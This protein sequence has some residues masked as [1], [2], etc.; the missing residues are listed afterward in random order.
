MKTVVRRPLRIA[1]VLGRFPDPTQ[2]FVVD[3]IAGI[4][5]RGHCVD[6][7]TTARPAR[8]ASLAGTLTRLNRLGL[9]ERRQALWEAGR[10]VLAVWKTLML[11]LAVGW[12]EPRVVHGAL[13]AMRTEGAAGGVRLL[14]AGLT[15]ARRGKPQYDAIHAQF[16]PYGRLAIRLVELDALQGPVVTSFRGY[17]AGRDLRANPRSY[18]NLFERGALF[19]PVSESL[20][21]RLRTGG[22]EAAKIRVQH[23]GIDCRTLR[24]RE[25]KLVEGGPVRIISIG[26]LVEKKGLRYGIDAV[27]RLIAASRPVSYA[28]VGDGP[29]RSA[30]EAHVRRC[31]LSAHVAFA[32]WKNHEEALDMLDASHI[33]LAPSVTA[34]DGDEEGIPN[35]VKEA[36]ALGVPVVATAHGGIGELIEDGKSGYLVAERDPEALAER[37]MH[38]IDHPERWAALGAAGRRAVEERFDAAKLNAELEGHYRAVSGEGVCQSEA[39]PI[40]GSHSMD[41]AARDAVGAR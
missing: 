23:S 16:G 33:L 32:G 31:N 10:P 26:R 41:G 24:Y 6:I 37:L 21:K 8:A 38:L 25:R 7:Y 18:R 39:D 1:Y 12:R 13:V 36:L 20:G 28:I 4:A 27:A 40:G 17:D 11:L 22:C 19:L 2:T 9:L 5:E 14:Y 15:L 30:L 34:D 3:Q 35:V 29:S